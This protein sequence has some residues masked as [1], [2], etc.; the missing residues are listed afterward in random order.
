MAEARPTVG[1][2]L[3]LLLTESFGIDCTKETSIPLQ[4]GRFTLMVVVKYTNRSG[5]RLTVSLH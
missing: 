3:S 4:S 2:W 5:I 1:M